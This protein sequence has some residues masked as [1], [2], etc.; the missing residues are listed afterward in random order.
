MTKPQPFPVNPNYQTVIRGLLRMYRLA[1]DGL[2]ESP[3]ADALRDAMDSPWEG[4]SDVERKRIAGLSE[5]LNAISE[6]TSAEPP[7]M[8]N[9]QAQAKLV[10]AGEARWRGEWDRALE[11]LRRWGKFAPPALVSYLRGAIWRAAGDAG[12]AAV[13][14][15]HAS[16]L[17][18]ENGGYQAVLLHVLKTADPVEAANRAEQILEDSE[19][20]TPIVVIQ[21]AEVAYRVAR[22]VSESQA[23]PMFMRLIPILERSLIKMDGSEDMD[24]PDLTVM[25]LSLLANCHQRIGDARRAYEY[26]SRAIQRDPR[27]E[28]L[29]IARGLIA[30]GTNLRAAADFEQAISLGS[31]LVWPYYFLAHYYLVNNRFEDCRLMCERGLDKPCPARVK[32][33]LYEFLA[34]AQAG[35]GYPE[36]PIRGAFEKAIRIDFSNERARRNLERFET[37][38]TSRAPQPK[39]WE[40]GSESSMRMMGLEEGW[41]DDALQERR[42]YA[43]I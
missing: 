24:G 4:L 7:S 14:F 21:A 35:L 32:S 15:E 18:P 39:D 37:A 13:F 3:E 43:A 8:T 38:L 12:T 30:Y 26:Y 6:I 27:N 19:A 25:A 34:L 33:E 1:A 36:E 2:F 23:G 28:T 9:P 20:R 31:T 10:Q 16:R 42:E 11:L 5:D 29:L 17:E 40:R 41:S 22:K